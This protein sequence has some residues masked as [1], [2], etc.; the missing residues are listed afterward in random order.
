[1]ERER[2]GELFVLTYAALE[3]V[4]PVVTVLS[5]R[6][7]SPM[8]SLGLSTIIAALFFGSVLT[9]RKKWGE[10]RHRAGLRDAVAAGVTIGIVYYTLTFWGL[11]YTSAGNESIIALT[12]VF[13]SFTFFTLFWGERHSLRHIV[14][15]LCMVVGALIVL[16]PNYYQGTIGDILILAA[17]AI[18]PLGN[19]FAQRAR[20]KISAETVMFVRSVIAGPS[21]LV[22]AILLGNS[23]SVD[24]ISVSLPLLLISGIVL[25]GFAK[26]LW[27]ESIHRISVPKANGLLC[28]RPFV[29][30]IVALLILRT[31]PTL[32]QLLAIVPMSVG[33]VLLS[34]RSAASRLVISDAV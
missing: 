18:A 24:M 7:L 33:V 9:I 16:S 19:F 26:L 14:G 12:E 25:L 1:M 6:T 10:L 21:I 13:F 22:V 20:K 17:A 31:P 4:L 5:L 27:I 30:L 8:I 32:W 2:K 28:V 11:K 3:G 29:T 15:A 23:V 34:M